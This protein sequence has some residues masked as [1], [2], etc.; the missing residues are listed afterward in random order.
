[1]SLFMWKTGMGFTH[2]YIFF[3]LAVSSEVVFINF[4]HCDFIKIFPIP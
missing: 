3:C 1:M 4:L 2:I